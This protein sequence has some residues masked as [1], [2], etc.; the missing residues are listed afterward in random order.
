MTDIILYEPGKFAISKSDDAAGRLAHAIADHG[1]KFSDLPK[2]EIPGKGPSF[3]AIETAAGQVAMKQLDCVIPLVISSQKGWWAED[4]QAGEPS[5]PP[6]CSSSD[7]ITGRGNHTLDQNPAGAKDS[8]DCVVCP[9][10]QWGS[11]RKGGKGKDCKDFAFMF[12]FGTE[13]R[14]PM[15]IKVPP[16]SLAPMREYFIKKL[17]GLGL[18]PWEVVTRLELHPEVRGQF[19]WHTIVFS[20]VAP[21]SGAEAERFKSIR[22]ILES[23]MR[24]TP[25]QITAGDYVK[26]D[27]Q[28]A[29]TS[30]TSAPA[31]AG[32]S[33]ASPGAAGAVPSDAFARGFANAAGGR[34]PEQAEADFPEPG[35]R[36]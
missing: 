13:S 5:R 16:T 25:P 12:L 11:D 18:E 19:N 34:A 27:A 20:L 9:W 24:R 32:P 17:V 8:H 28:P 26:R 4:P 6:N 36:G 30:G 29:A 21:L 15:V 14:L 3:W 23:Q 10:N 33:V 7:A 2:L 35:S 31:S 22:A 1:I